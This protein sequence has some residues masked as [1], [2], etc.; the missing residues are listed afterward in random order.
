MSNSVHSKKNRDL[1][2]NVFDK[3]ER[4]ALKTF[5]LPTAFFIFQSLIKDND[6]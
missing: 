4:R 5:L 6:G 2:S 1:R 3:P